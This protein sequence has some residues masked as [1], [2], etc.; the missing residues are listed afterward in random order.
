MSDSACFCAI[1]GGPFG[2]LVFS[3]PHPEGPP[4]SDDESDLDGFTAHSDAAWSGPEDDSD[5]DDES[6]NQ[7]SDSLDTTDANSHT[8]E[9]AAIALSDDDETEE[10]EAT[11][12]ED[13]DLSEFESESDGN[14]EETDINLDDMAPSEGEVES[15]DEEM[16]HN[17]EFLFDDIHWSEM[18]G[19]GYDRNI[20]KPRHTHW[21]RTVHALGC[22]MKAPGPSKCYLSGRGVADWHTGTVS[23]TPGPVRLRDPNYPRIRGRRRPLLDVLT[24]IDYAFEDRRKWVFPVHMPCLKVLCQVLTGQPDPYDNLKL[25]KDA[26]Y[27][28]MNNLIDW[29]GGALDITYFADQP[30]VPEYWESTPGKEHIH[31]N[32]L[33]TEDPHRKQVL[34][35]VSTAI[36][37]LS[38]RN[39][40]LDDLTPK[41]KSD[42]FSKLPYDLIYLI[43]GH[44]ADRDLFSLC[45]ASYIVHQD[46]AQNEKFWRL[47]LTKVS[48]PWFEE[49][50]EDSKDLLQGKDWKVL[51]CTLQ[52]LLCSR[53]YARQGPL[54]GVYNRR[55]I[56]GVCQRIAREY[57]AKVRELRERG[58]AAV[59]KDFKR[60]CASG[61]EVDLSAGVTW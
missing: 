23:F 18:P 44:L 28:A 5:E 25:D 51:M 11:H 50:L 39:Y 53:K 57:F 48:M 46:L 59:F 55:R 58:S 15:E 26:L 33:S 9:H 1:C 34:D 40:L 6:Q 49:V 13:D 47:R 31:A 45:S 52:K 24:Y 10:D 17:N 60:Y 27:F 8:S 21:I 37:T 29:A 41:V 22:N 56:W 19:R 43:T 30:L 35:L 36:K 14:H 12:S 16:I 3:P 7:D 20:L 54:M 2:D 61:G 4:D 38:N 42:G 32:P